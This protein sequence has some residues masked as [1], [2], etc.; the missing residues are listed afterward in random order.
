MTAD[1]QKRLAFHRAGE[2]VAGYL[3]GVPLPTTASVTK[4]IRKQFGRPN[5]EAL[6]HFFGVLCE[7]KG[8]LDFDPATAGPAAKAAGDLLGDDAERTDQ[9]WAVARCWFRIKAID[10]AVRDLALV[11]LD[12]RAVDAGEVE[13][14]CAAY[15][16]PRGGRAG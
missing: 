8:G 9:L 15:G 6:T 4:S 3:T 2:L 7:A 14:C 12:G 1:R 11:L 10:A 16:L 13:R 5:P